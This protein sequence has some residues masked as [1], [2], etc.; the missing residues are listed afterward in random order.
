MGS[1]SFPGV[2]TEEDER[3]NIFKNQEEEAQSLLFKLW[4][5]LTWMTAFSGR[6]LL[7]PVTLK[8]ASTQFQS[9]TSMTQPN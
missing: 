9:Y 3:W 6:T 5:S 2:R 1:L 7:E 8:R 4:G